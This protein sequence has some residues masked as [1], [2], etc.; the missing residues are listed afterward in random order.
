MFFFFYIIY[1]IIVIIEKLAFGIAVPG[2]A[3]IVVLILFLGGLQLLAL[4]INGEYLSRTYIQS[5]HRPIYIAREVI[6][7]CDD[8]NDI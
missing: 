5:K 2:Y 8:K 4:G 1:I 7:N 3:T 6:S